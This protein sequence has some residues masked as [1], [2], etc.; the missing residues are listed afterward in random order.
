MG[1]RHFREGFS[2][3]VYGVKFSKGRLRTLCESERPAFGI[4]WPNTGSLDPG[5]VKAVWNIVTGD[6]GHQDQ[7][8]Y[9]DKWLDLVSESPTG[10]KKLCSAD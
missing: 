7:F 10:V 8:P 2:D 1:G 9:I 6:P 3:D 5:L 4:G